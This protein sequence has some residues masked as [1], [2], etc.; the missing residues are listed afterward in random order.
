MR[1]RDELNFSYRQ[2]SLHDLAILEAQF[3]F[4]SE[5]PARLTKRLQKLWI[6]CCAQQPMAQEN[7]AYVFKDHGGE[8][9][10]KLIDL[11]GLKSTRVGQVEISAR[12]SN[13][14]VANPGVP[15]TT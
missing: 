6:A 1:S 5:D 4:E 11:A 3:K 10:G 7:S 2:S 9:A 15:A 8:A 13:F 12:D 14:I